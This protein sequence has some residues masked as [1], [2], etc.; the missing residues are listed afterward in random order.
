MSLAFALFAL[1]FASSSGDATEITQP[2]WLRWGASERQ[3]AA[4]AA[5]LCTR[6]TTRQINPPFLTNVRTQRQ[7]DCEGLRF[8]GGARRA[9]FVIGDDRLEMV[10][11]LIEPAELDRAAAAMR[12]AYGRPT[13]SRESITGFPGQRTALRREP[14]ELLFYSPRQAAEWR[15]WF[16][17]P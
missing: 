6:Y 9:E 13:A 2:R 4:Q 3:I 11:I 7:I 12:T 1:A 8:W 15:A 16:E 10:W 5:R 14:A 17:R